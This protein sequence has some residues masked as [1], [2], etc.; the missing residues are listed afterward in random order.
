MTITPQ[1]AAGSIE[2]GGRTYYFCSSHCLQKFRRDPSLHVGADHR[3]P[4]PPEAQQPPAVYTC[5][6]HPQVRQPSPGACPICGMALEPAMPSAGDEANPELADMSRRFW[7]SLTL[8]TPLVLL[9]MAEHLVDLPHNLSRPSRLLQLVLATPVVLWGG[10]VF[11]IRMW[12]SLVSGRLN[13]FTLIG[14]GTAVAYGFSV[15][16]VAAPGLFPPEFRSHDEVGVYFEAAAAIVTLVLLGQVLELRAR[17]RAG[18][19]IRGLLDLAPRQAHVLQDGRETDV[20]LAQVV[21]GQRLRVRPG[22]KAPVDGTVIE[23]A[24]AIDESML[25]GEAMPVQK[26]VGDSVS[27]GTLNGMGSFVMQATKVGAQTLLAQIVAMVASAQRSRAPIQRLADKVSAWFVPAVVAAA[28]ITFIVWAAWGPQ[29]AMAYA[30]VNAV[31]VLIIACPCALGL[32]TPMAVMVAAGRGARQGVLARD[33][34]A[35]ETMEKVDVLVVD[36][37][38][39]LTEGR[40]RVA[41]VVPAGGA[42]ADEALATAAALETG[43]EHPLARAV[44]QAA[45]ERSIRPPPAKDFHAIGGQG[46]VG[47]VAGK[48]AMVGSSDLLARNGVDCSPL[49]RQAQEMAQRGATIM[50]VAHGGRLLGLLAAEDTVRPEAAE[51]IA[52]LRRWGVRVVL[53]TGDNARAAASVAGRLGIDEFHAGLLPGQKGELIRRLQSAGHTVA[54]AGDGVNDAPA[55]ALADVGIAMGAGADVAM[56]SAGVTLLHGD[57]RGIVRARLLSRRTMKTIRQNLFFAFIYNAL[58]VPLAAGVLWPLTGALL[59]PVVAA[60]AMSFSSVSVIANSL[61]LAKLRLPRFP[62]RQP[63]VAG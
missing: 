26:G 51:M 17:A 21:V 10:W 53:A 42:T 12:R 57:L 30:V 15:V 58:G 41:Q 46:V 27:A 8:T 52:T 14:L 22:E 60:A 54:M 63:A 47:D 59:S 56:E 35:L 5:P 2:H 44:V 49:D 29:P 43:S 19:A 39:T 3:P 13:M 61:R 7:V 38:G 23:G 62:G 18:A 48:T 40:P 20:P 36:K 4:Q 45:A 33:A 37:T 32:A 9:A 6:M 11:F 1:N 50:F 31:A 55:L 34:A 28:F 24:S 16:A 25:T